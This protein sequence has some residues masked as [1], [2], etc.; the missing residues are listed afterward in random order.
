MSPVLL[1][2]TN[3]A[4]CCL[5]L[6]AIC[7]SLAK[8][9]A[10]SISSTS[11][12]SITIISNCSS[13]AKKLGEIDERISAYPYAHRHTHRH[14]HYT[15][16]FSPSCSYPYLLFRRIIRSSIYSSFHQ[17]IYPAAATSVKVF[18]PFHTAVSCFY[19]NLTVLSPMLNCFILLSNFLFQ[20][21]FFFAAF[22]VYFL[23]SFF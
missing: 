11:S 19:R 17:Y 5:L 15:Q 8:A 23:S 13:I 7:T 18:Q 6:F 10:T 1:K 12:S 21:I 3:Q 22:F 9:S 16:T 14:I 2:M 20:M 4:Y